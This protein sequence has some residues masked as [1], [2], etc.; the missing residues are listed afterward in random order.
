MSAA[1][2]RPLAWGVLLLAAAAAMLWHGCSAPEQSAEVASVARV[3]ETIVV[4]DELFAGRAYADA[5]EAYR[6]AITYLDRLDEVD[7]A[8][9]SYRTL[10]ASVEVRSNLAALGVALTQ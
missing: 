4:G 6:T 5:L 7:E 2:C 10:R 9:R 3:E 1:A 8:A